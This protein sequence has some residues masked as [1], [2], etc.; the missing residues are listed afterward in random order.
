VGALG[1]ANVVNY[2]IGN[3]QQRGEND[4]FTVLTPKS[5]R[6]CPKVKKGIRV[7]PKA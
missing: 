2:T 4:L 6:I 7:N 1:F 3:R 5:N